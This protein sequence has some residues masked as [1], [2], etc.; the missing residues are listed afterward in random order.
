MKKN[1]I[2]GR[3]VTYFGF[4]E[5]SSFLEIIQKI[6]L[7]YIY[8]IEEILYKKRCIIEKSKIKGWLG[9]DSVLEVVCGEYTMMLSCESRVK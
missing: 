7:Y 9:L 5:I 3:S 2:F 8:C 4:L 1:I 6:Q